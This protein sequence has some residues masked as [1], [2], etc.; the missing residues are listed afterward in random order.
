M[1]DPA[2]E[3]TV[4]EDFNAVDDLTPAQTNAMGEALNDLIV[5]G[6]TPGA[7]R[8]GIDNEVFDVSGVQSVDNLLKSLFANIFF[9]LTGKSTITISATG[10]AE[11][12]PS[13]IELANGEMVCAYRTANDVKCR[14]STD[15]GS[16]WGAEIT[17]YAGGSV[18]ESPYLLQLA[19]DD[20]LCFF[21][22]N[23]DAGQIHIKFM[24]STD[25]GATWG[26][27]T[28]VYTDDAALTSSAVQLENGDI[29]CFFAT[30]ED[31]DSHIKSLK[32]ANNG[33]T[34]TDKTDVYTSA[35]SFYPHCIV[36]DDSWLL[37]FKEGTSNKF[38]KSTDN[39][40]TWSAVI[41]SYTMTTG[42]TQ[43]MLSLTTGRVFS[44]FRDTGD[45]KYTYSDDR[46]VTWATSIVITASTLEFPDVCQKADKEILLA[47]RDT[48]DI[49]C[50]KDI[51][52]RLVL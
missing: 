21:S 20:V 52:A 27:K 3:N 41:G 51:W 28:D 17:V 36:F 30:T 15:G 7:S 6:A 45:L 24:K 12:F 31:G 13:I 26:T 38:I 48:N 8:V 49:K 34:W 32:S 35:I 22:T 40:L 2:W 9:D 43:R 23:E 19:N 25:D 16:T 33:A 42:A 50:Y 5:A 14:K 18:D 46:G 44:F 10:A 39:G 37:G 11:T 4:K 1:S 47:F 29:F